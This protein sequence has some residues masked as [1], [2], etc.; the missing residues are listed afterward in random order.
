MNF[1]PGAKGLPNIPRMGMRMQIPD[2]YNNVNWFGRGPEENYSDRNTGAFVGLYEK[3]VDDLYF[4]YASPQENGN[5]TDTR[6]IA[7]TGDQGAGLMVTGAPIL[8]WSALYFTQED[9]SQE[10]RGTKH[11]SD[12]QK[13][14]FISLNLDHKQMG[15]GG[16]TSWGAWPHGEYR[17]PPREYSYNFR[18]SPVKPN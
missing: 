13:R 10:D 7:L 16:D 2:K 1:K 6:W 9:L 12:L 17:L 11:T 5:R 14:D 4:A 18:L 8:S 15:V 3:S